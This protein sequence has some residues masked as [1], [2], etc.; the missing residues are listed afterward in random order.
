MFKIVAAWSLKKA[1]NEF[2]QLNTADMPTKFWSNLSKILDS[3]SMGIEYSLGHNAS[4]IFRVAKTP[5]PQNPKTPRLALIFFE[6]IN[7][8]LDLNFE[9]PM[10]ETEVGL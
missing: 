3:R 5:K 7:S 2:K 4:M 10:T 9:Q 6:Y 8:L 1:M